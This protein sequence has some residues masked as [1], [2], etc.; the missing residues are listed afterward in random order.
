MGVFASLGED[1]SGYSET[2]IF[3]GDSFAYTL[4]SL[5]V[6]NYG[7][8]VLFNSISPGSEG[9][10]LYDVEDQSF[11]ADLLSYS[12][13]VEVGFIGGGEAINRA[14]IGILNSNGK[15]Q[16]VRNVTESFT[17]F[18]ILAGPTI[19][20]ITFSES[21][22]IAFQD[23]DSSTIQLVDVDTRGDLESQAAMFTLRESDIVNQLSLAPSFNGT[24]MDIGIVG[25]LA[26]IGGDTDTE[27]YRIS[28]NPQAS[29]GQRF[30]RA[31]PATY[32]PVTGQQ[33]NSVFD[34]SSSIAS[35]SGAY[36]ALEDLKSLKTQIEK[37][38]G[39]LDEAQK[40]IGANIELIRE[41]GR[42]MLDLSSQLKTE[43]DADT[44]AEELKERIRAIGGSAVQAQAGNLQSIIVA[45]LTRNEGSD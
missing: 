11:I 25:S 16:G 27:L 9:V 29:T 34:E 23:N 6:N 14:V 10:Y 19:G 38:L 15:L 41:A 5:D 31:S 30:S 26:S 40:V 17:I 18:S 28:A 21:G 20:E 13:A 33:F 22:Y 32:D 35:R 42:A 7:S 4:N 1:P 36:R 44:L 12:T 8:A 24:G 39:A 45:A 43:K 2:E 3:T 37:N